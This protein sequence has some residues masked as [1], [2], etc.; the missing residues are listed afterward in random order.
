MRPCSPVVEGLEHFEVECGKGQP[1]FLVLPVLIGAKPNVT[2]ISRWVP[3]DVERKQ[4]AAGA[5]IY[6]MQNTYGT[7]Y[8][9]MA[10]AVATANQ[11]PAVVIEHFG[12]GKIL[13]PENINEVLDSLLGLK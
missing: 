13:F 9:P 12:V 2:F 11:D 7:G 3:T 1:D 8:A 10:L 5:D 4:I 6:T